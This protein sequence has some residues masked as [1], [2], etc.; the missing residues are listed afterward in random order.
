[1]VQTASAAKTVLQQLPST[2]TQLS[3][4]KQTLTSDA[5]KENLDKGMADLINST[6]RLV[7]LINQPDQSKSLVKTVIQ[8]LGDYYK[9][10]DPKSLASKN[11]MNSAIKL[12]NAAITQAGTVNTSWDNVKIEQGGRVDLTPSPN[13]II[14][15]ARNA[16]QTEAELETQLSESLEG[17]LENAIISTVTLKMPDSL[18]NAPKTAAGLNAQTMTAL[19]DNNIEK[20]NL[21]LGAVSFGIDD[22]FIEAQQSTDLSFNVDRERPLSEA[23]RDRMPKGSHPVGAPVVNLSATQNKQAND[24]FNHP[25]DVSFHLD[26][27]DNV[28]KDPTSLGIFRL[29]E[30]TNNWE[31]VGGVYDPATN[32][33]HT[34]RTHLSKYTV[35]QSEKNYSNIEDSWA[36]NEIASLKGKGIIEDDEL[37]TAS[38]NVTREEFAGWI[39][40]AYGLDSST[41]ETDL[42]D[43]DKD[44][45][46]YGAVA[47]AYQQ[48]I[49]SGKADGTFDPKGDISKEEMAV[50][51]ASAMNKYDYTVDTNTF[52]LAQ[53][54]EDLPTW[55]VN[56]VETVVENGAVDESF[57]GS[58]GSVTKEEAA[59]ILY[60][61][62]R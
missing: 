31:P 32:S 57:F 29:N 10:I 14:Q 46:Y 53:Y 59:A 61:V 22:K 28:P 52:E 9:G 54:E 2:L 60:Q 34:K 5:D 35:L 38:D 7:A 47:A 27:F 42:S 18:K 43:L 55:A 36:K 56:S 50:M 44:S 62:Y 24:T 11:L 16:A 17:G 51:I 26:Q 21:D 37:F 13:Q 40:K 12:S 8:P 33:I 30:S 58:A 48:G 23:D 20:V 39:A 1:K 15:A 25:L 41:M 3:A 6:E 4:A 19:K 49:I 45:P